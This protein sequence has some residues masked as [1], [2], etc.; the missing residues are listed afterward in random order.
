MEAIEQAEGEDGGVDVEPGGEAGGDHKGSEI[1]RGEGHVRDCRR[2]RPC[3]IEDAMHQAKRKGS[4]V[5][6]PFLRLLKA[7]AYAT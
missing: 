5:G 7:S 1:G 2:I 4:L 3:R 6:L